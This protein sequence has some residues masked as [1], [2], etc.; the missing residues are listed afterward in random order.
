MRAKSAST[1][2]AV[3]QG[4]ERMDK[5]FD[6]LVEI[7]KQGFENTNVVIKQGFENTNTVI[8][9]GFEGMDKRLENIDKRLDALT[10]EIRG[11]QRRL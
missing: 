8:R 6:D 11:Y 9:Q 2:E 1:E 3:R 7:I 4:F 5:R 10:A